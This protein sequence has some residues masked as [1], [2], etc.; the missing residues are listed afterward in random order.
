MKS[1]FDDLTTGLQQA[2]DYEKGAGYALRIL[3]GYA[4]CKYLAFC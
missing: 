3:A 1:L 4:S 2:I